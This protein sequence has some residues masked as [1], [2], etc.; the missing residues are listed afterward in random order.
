MK[1]NLALSLS[2][3]LGALTA[4]GC[5]DD[6]SSGSSLGADQIVYSSRTT[7]KFSI[8]AMNASD[9]SAKTQLP[10]TDA[11]DYGPA[12]SPDGQDLAF[13][14]DKTGKSQIYRMQADGGAPAV[15]VT[16]DD[17]NQVSPTWSPD[18]LR[19]AYASDR[20]DPFRQI[21]E[22]YTIDRDG[23][24]E[25]QITSDPDPDDSFQASNTAPD[26][27]ASPN[28]IAFVS[29][30]DNVGNDLGTDIFAINPTGSG[31]VSDTP[32]A[33]GFTT[34]A[35]GGFHSLA[36]ASDGSISAWGHDNSG[37]V[38]DAPTD[39]G[40][41]AIAG[42]D[43][44]SMA[45][46]GDGSIVT[47]GDDSAATWANSSTGQVSGTPTGGGFTA[48]AAGAFHNLA[49]AADGSIHAWGSNTSGQVSDAPTGTGYIAIAAGTAHSLALAPN[50]SIVS[51]GNDDYGQVSNTPVLAPV[52]PGN[53]LCDTPAPLVFVAIA[54]ND[55]YSLA[56]HHISEGSPCESG[57]L[58]SW[59]DD[60]AE[61]VSGTPLSGNDVAIAA[62]KG[63]SM[64]LDAFGR[65]RAWGD[66]ASGQVSDRP[67]GRGF[68]EI[69]AGGYHSLTLASDGSI[70]SWGNDGRGQPVPLTRTPS[71][72][73]DSDPAWSPDGSRI[74]FTSNRGGNNDIFVMNADGTGQVN[75]TNSFGA[76][77]W[78][79]WSPDGT[80]IAFETYRNVKWEI[81][82]MNASD[83]SGQEPRDDGSSEWNFS[84][85]WS[86]SPAP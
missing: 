52:I 48:I 18:G 54:A 49:L 40:Y 42:G 68:T 66:D 20:T 57:D 34:I 76:D 44:H 8:Y 50:G 65:I 5:G 61:Q 37:Q 84:P 26:W 12:W 72:K 67:T 28:R 9:G 78:P 45:L 22:I 81:Y 13:F 19:L 79:S 36:L 58:W 11:N 74:A 33:T 15:Q 38:S 73:A 62:G 59:G 6:A 43:Y 82:V 2:I 83:G 63:H 35:G 32:T 29:D 23:N 46:A 14:S 56:L 77:Q 60:Y 80:Q 25:T 3:A 4:F 64:A 51:W 16:T 31:Q 85:A 53:P 70:T 75:L 86:P 17:S 69:A 27:S 10:G 55:F 47:W 39:S 21:F 1:A 71:P 7:G 41:V 30:R 24:N